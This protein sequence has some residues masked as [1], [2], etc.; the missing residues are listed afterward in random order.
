MG[1]LLG[2]LHLVETQDQ[3]QTLMAEKRYR[4][5]E[6]YSKTPRRDVMPRDRAHIGDL[7]EE[8]M[9][10]GKEEGRDRSLGTE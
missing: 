10:V 4:G 7:L 8:E 2:I 6:I 3:S 1:P 5:F 9:E